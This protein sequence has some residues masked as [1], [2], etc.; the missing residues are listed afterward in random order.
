MLI[1]LLVYERAM[2]VNPSEVIAVTAQLIMAPTNT[3]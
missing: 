3:I 2:K 1:K